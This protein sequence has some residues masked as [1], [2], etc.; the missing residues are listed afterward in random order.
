VKRPPPG[1]PTG[2]Q[3]GE[4]EAPDPDAEPEWTLDTLTAAAQERGV[5]VVQRG[6]RV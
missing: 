3:T 2:E 4:L 5:Q 1:K 6:L